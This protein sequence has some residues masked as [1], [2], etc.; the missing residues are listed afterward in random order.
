MYDSISQSDK[1]KNIRKILNK[2]KSQSEAIILV[3]ETRHCAEVCM[4]RAVTSN[5]CVF[6]QLSKT[7]THLANYIEQKEKTS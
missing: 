2:A 5:D 1:Q 6:E 7:M 3:S 4:A